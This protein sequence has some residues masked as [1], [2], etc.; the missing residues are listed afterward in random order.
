MAPIS[1]AASGTRNLTAQ[2]VGRISAAGSYQWPGLYFEAKFEGRSVYFKIGDG[3]V[4]LHVLVDGQSVGTLV[5]PAPG[6]YLI[7]GLTKHAH[8]VRIDAVTESQSAPNTFGGFALPTAG[9]VLPV[10]PRQRQIEF[11]GD[12]HTV[13]YGN[14]SRTRDCTETEVWATTDTFQSYG[15]KVARRFDADY[16]INAISGRGI[17]RNYDGFL[18]D[19]L[20]LV[21]PFVLFDHAARY[22]NAAWQPQIIVIALGTN[23]FSTPLKSGEKWK[24]RDALR[25]DFEATYVKF[26]ESLRVRNRNAFFILWATDLADHEIEQEAGKVVE[27]LQSKGEDRVA[28]VPINGLAMTGC[29]WHPSVA[30]HQVIADGLIRFIDVRNLAGDAR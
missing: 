19:P 2:I 23:D 8:T 18:A 1:G 7:D 14:T 17:V 4:I 11:I 28:F 13:G 16:Q 5:K 9:K 21:Y 30:D 12:S 27:Q 24:T 22:D 25:A 26:V 3:D 29:N 15:P 6:T 10:T 20:P